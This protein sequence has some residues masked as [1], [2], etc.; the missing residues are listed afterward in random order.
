MMMV[1]TAMVILIEIIITMNRN[2]DDNIVDVFV[3]FN[4]Y[5]LCCVVVA[6]DVT[7]IVVARILCLISC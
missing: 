2:G 1:M 3:F 4:I 7:T 5:I 6:K